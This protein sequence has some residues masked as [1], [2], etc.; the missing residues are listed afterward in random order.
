MILC[1]MSCRKITQTLEGVS[2]WC[3]YEFV[4]QRPQWICVLRIAAGMYKAVDQPHGHSTIPPFQIP[5]NLDTQFTISLLLLFTDFSLDM[6][7]RVSSRW[8]IHSHIRAAPR[9]NNY[10]RSCDFIL[11]SDWHATIVARKHERQTR[12]TRPFLDSFVGWSGS[13]DWVRGTSY[14]Y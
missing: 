11:D 6:H 2:D 7:D 12:L 5:P 3:R 10:C 14:F 4:E 1:D 13:R 9:P 8:T